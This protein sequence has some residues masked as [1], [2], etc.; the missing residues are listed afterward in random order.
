MD[1]T[2]PDQIKHEDEH[3]LS[4]LDILTVFVKQRYLIIIVTI[5]GTVL[6]LGF[7]VYTAVMPDSSRWNPLPNYFEAKTKVLLQQKG[8]RL[9]PQYGGSQDVLSFILGGSVQSSSSSIL[10]A[11]ELLKG[12][13]L[14]DRVIDELELLHRLDRPD[15]EVARNGLRGR[16]GRSLFL[17]EIAARSTSNILLLQYRDKDPEL[18]YDILKKIIEILEERF[19]GLS[20]ERVLAQKGFV[21]E[22]MGIVEKDLLSA[23][24]N[25]VAFHEKYGIIDVSSFAKEQSQTIGKLKADVL[26]LQV[27]LDSYREYMTEDDPRVERLKKE[28]KAG[29]DYIR[30]VESEMHADSVPAIMDQYFNLEREL[31]VHLAIYTTLRSEYESV[32]I[33]EADTAKSLQVIEYPEIPLRKSGPNRKKICI[34]GALGAF[35][36]S[37]LLAFFL[38]YLDRAKQNPVEARKIE[39]MKA[40]IRRRRRGK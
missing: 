16:I 26:E 27:K 6:T 11:M 4:L 23:Q 8:Q 2:S 39:L 35:F 37:V 28:I 33:E 18:A 36:L 31:E 3:T 7:A 30:T 17:P 9:T 21:Q 25:I 13:T 38:S 5:I 10:L 15:T 12:N 20:L 29:E 32:K 34:F 14:K 19:R 40:M 24:K 22:R 1:Q